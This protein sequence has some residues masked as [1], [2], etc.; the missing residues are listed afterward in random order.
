VQFAKKIGATSLLKVGAALE[1]PCAAA[2]TEK[3]KPETHTN[4]PPRSLVTI[5]QHYPM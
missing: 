2:G 5:A 1:A 3:A 4:S